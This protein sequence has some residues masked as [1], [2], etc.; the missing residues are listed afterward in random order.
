MLRR[1]LSLSLVGSVAVAACADATEAPRVAIVT[2]LALPKGVLD[3]V[4]KL[5]LTVLEGAVS[6]DPALGQVSF[7]SGAAAATELKSQVL[8]STGCAAGARFCGD[9][10]ID[11]SATPRVFSAV[12]KGAGDV[13]LA[14]GCTQAVVN[15]DALPIAIK[16]VRFLAPAN[17]GD[18]VLQPTEQ[19]EPGGTAACDANC[20]SNETLLSVGSTLGNT[21]TGTVGDKSEPFLLWP[22]QSGTQG[23]FFAF[24][25][26][27]TIKTANNAEVAL[28]AMTDDLSPIAAGDSPALAAGEIYL[29]NDKNVFPPQ[30][31]PRL[32]STP[33]AAFV[34]GKYY[35]AFQDDTGT[36]TGLD[37]HLRSMDTA[38][39]ADQ[40][41]TPLGINGING[42]GEAA[43]QQAPAIA[44][45][46]Q[47]RLF[48]AWEDAGQGKIAGRIL[49]PPS[50]LGS[51]NDLS[52]GNGNKGVSV[53]ALG[54][55]WVAVWQS[56][57]G[58]KL[59]IVNADGTPQGSEQTVNEGGTV[60]ERPRVASL[61]DGRFA[62]TWSSGS[63]VFVQRY[64]AKGSKIVGDQASPI[65]DVVVDGDQTTPSIA[66][67]PAAS[68]SY[69]VTW[70][71]VG[72]SN[73]RA[74]ML[75]G[76]AGF[77][78]NNVNGQ[79]SEFQASRTDGRTRANPVVAVGGSA[80]FVAIAWEDQTAPGAGIVA[81][82]F[83]L[84]SE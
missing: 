31:A 45:G 80:P 58:I 25:T 2:N 32:Q 14:I 15:Q 75:G 27:R 68:G 10:A 56:G 59:R 55:G 39:V 69:V 33:S 47:D 48:V 46:P 19:C 82:R 43:I 44:A 6:C 7:P 12:A 57:T 67:T 52:T 73:I 84:P 23:R 81:R 17:C 38:L 72:S 76:S 51:Q 62:V 71:D 42:A 30:P 24:Y 22:Q 26:D 79:S 13:T 9:I 53:A 20:Q 4:T 78:F 37:I 29:P 40:G 5:T 8:G 50:T 60:N 18:G 74:R 11:R 3:K 66:G 41:A 61:A 1:V 49:T 77:L 70:L 83:P 21:Q 16:M 28:R 64:D 35:V 36:A 65:N 63:D 54:T 34:N